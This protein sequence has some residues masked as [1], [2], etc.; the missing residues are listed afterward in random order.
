MKLVT[1]ATHSDG[2]YS[3]L[4]QS[5]SRYHVP[6]TVLGFGTK[7]KGYSH[8][9][10]LMKEFLD[11]QPDHELIC[12]IDSFDVILLRSFDELESEY[13]KMV[14]RI[15]VS[16]IIGC[17]KANSVWTEY[18][19]KLIFGTCCG[20][21]LNS[22]TYIGPVSDLKKMMDKIIPGQLD[23]D[24][25]TLIS[26]YARR[27]PD[28]IYIDH[29]NELFLTVTNAKGH[30]LT[31]EMAFKHNQFFYKKNKPFLAHGNGNTNMND[32]LLLLGYSLSQKEKRRVTEYHET[33]FNKKIFYYAK[34][35]LPYLLL[36]IVILSLCIYF[37]VKRIRNY[38]KNE[39]IKPFLS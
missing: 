5:C 23:K 14:N 19:M 32:L 31:K 4:Q 8:K 2:Y 7:W 11:Q 27:Y 33:E 36:L 17:E 16:I 38:Y 35:V 9:L 10:L 20:K 3:Y 30:F 26:Q 25:Q 28:R 37:L 24:D 13:Q 18:A 34:R 22:G 6:L 39:K 12:F 21:L 15:G 1:V 29:E